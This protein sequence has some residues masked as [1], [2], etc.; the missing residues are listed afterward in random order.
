MIRTV[1]ELKKLLSAYNPDIEISVLSH[2]HEG[3]NGFVID[4][5]EICHHNDPNKVSLVMVAYDSPA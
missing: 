5:L 1:G 4:R 3:K 2:V